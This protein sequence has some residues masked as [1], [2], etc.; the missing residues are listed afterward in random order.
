VSRDPRT[1]MRVHLLKTLWAAVGLFTSCVILSCGGLGGHSLS[2]AGD[3]A[4]A[5]VGHET[6]TLAALTHWMRALSSGQPLPDPPRYAH[7]IERERLNGASA[8][9]T[10][11]KVSCE[12]QY[13]SAQKQALGFLLTLAWIKEEAAR[14]RVAA[15]RPDEALR[16]RSTSPRSVFPRATSADV[17]VLA[18]VE[19]DISRI[20]SEV[21]RRQ[22]RI[23]P[24]RIAHYYVEHRQS[25]DRPEWRS[26]NIVEQIKSPASARRLISALRRA[27]AGIGLLFAHPR[28][29]AG[30]AVHEVR[31]KP[32]HIATQP[33]VW[34]AIFSAP[35]HLLVGPVPLFQHYAILEVLR[36]FSAHR[37]SRAWLSQTIGSRLA[38]AQGRR[39]LAAFV[40]LWRTRWTRRTVCGAKYL[41]EQCRGYRGATKTED[42]FVARVILEGLG[43]AYL[44]R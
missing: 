3:T 4:V 11:L 23:S 43:R 7:C 25:F 15:M 13:T 27:G 6:I 18:L 14:S 2:R 17:K 28:P 21:M 10:G 44:H 30:V 37:P 32:P 42:P 5:R 22:P 29:D 40:D 36:V 34:H 16:A 12:E 35:P 41:V 39:A 1:P 24:R 26:F 31:E 19:R 9:E 33:P 8:D 38:A 20:R